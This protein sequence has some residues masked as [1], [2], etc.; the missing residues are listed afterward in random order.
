VQARGL[1]LDLAGGELGVLVFAARDDRAGDRDAELRAQLAGER[2]RLAV[3]VGAEDHLGDASAV[4]QIDEHAPA[5]IAAGGDP[6][7]ERDR[8]T[9]VARAQIAAIVRS[10]DVDEVG[11]ASGVGGSYRHGADYNAGRQLVNASHPEAARQAWVVIDGSALTL[12]IDAP[13]EMIVRLKVVKIELA[14]CPVCG[15]AYDPLRARAVL[16]TDGKVRAFCSPP[17]KARAQ[18]PEEPAIPDEETPPLGPRW[19]RISFRE[20]L[21]VL[22]AGAAVLVIGWKLGGF[23]AHATASMPPLHIA[24][25]PPP[26]PTTAQ[27]MAILAS[28]SGP[29]ADVWYHP[30]PGPERVLPMRDTRRFGAAREGMRP[31]ECVG[32]HCGVDIGIIRGQLVLASHDGVVERVER[33]PE[34]GGRRGNE[35]RFIRINHKGGTVVTSYM[36]LDA[37]REDLKPGI[38]VKAGEAIATVGDSGVHQSG[39]HLHFA[40]SVRASGDG[41]ELFINPEPLLLLWPLAKRPASTLHAMT[42]TVP[43]HARTAQAEASSGDL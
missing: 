12:S 7:H 24:P 36:H 39:P 42:A 21:G 18:R 35:G 41:A 13:K 43:R 11:A 32:G 20:T 17:C 26:P 9:D 19:Q 34:V 31:E 29:E 10:L 3:D 30:I 5:V 14:T 4:A 8:M 16:V 27:A 28:N 38:P 25:P 2:V 6:A 37:I 23:G 1:D 40:V 15:A 22:L 33:D